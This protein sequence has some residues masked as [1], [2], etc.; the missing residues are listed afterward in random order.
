MNCK[1][2]LSLLEDYLYRQLNATADKQLATHLGACEVCA[3]EYSLR[4]S[5]QKIYAGCEVRV[6]PEFWAGVQARIQQE[7]GLRSEM[8]APLAALWSGFRF[9]P[10]LAAAAGCLVLVCLAA[11]SLYVGT[12]SE[13]GRAT[14]AERQDKQPLGAAPAKQDN[15]VQVLEA[16]EKS[17]SPLDHS[18]QNV[19]RHTGLALKRAS[20]GRAPVASEYAMKRIEERA[21]GGEVLAEPNSLLAARTNIG[22][23]LD[24]DSARHIE[25]AEMLLRSFKNSRFLPAA[26]TSE[27]NYER[28][29]SKDLVGSNI[30]LRRDAELAGNVALARLLDRLEPFLLEIAN[31]QENSGR[32]EIRLVREGLMREQI[33]AALQSF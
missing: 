26:Y 29:L 22:S 23:D 2:C 28:R 5:E 18:E 30:L 9:N 21:S 14:T 6:G 27:L 1:E 8:L 32:K 7:K 31:L 24:A 19:P 12:R 10:A 17:K 16:G 33:I 20:S 4:R 13:T 3:G 11:L 15:T 25:R